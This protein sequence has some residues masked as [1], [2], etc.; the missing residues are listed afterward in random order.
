L[1]TTAVES[2]VQR[3]RAHHEQSERIQQRTGWSPGPAGRYVADMFVAD[4]HR[5]DDPIVTRLR[6]AVTPATTVLDVGGG[7]G[8]YALPLALVCK[9]VTVVEPDPGMVGALRDQMEKHAIS[10][11][12]VVE[13]KWQ[14][15]AAGAADVVLCAHMIYDVVDIQGFVQ[16]L[17]GHARERIM[18]LALLAWPIGS[19]SPIWP[20]V[21]N[22]QRVSLPSVPKLL[23]VLWELGIYPDLEMLALQW[24]AY[25]KDRDAVLARLRRMIYVQPDSEPDARLRAALDELTVETPQGVTLR[26]ARPNR[27]CLVT[28]PANG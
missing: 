15:T 7:A 23:P 8:R 10:N 20:R 3:V 5:E 18:L 27:E 11:I 25:A 26:D 13:E 12:T 17:T 1:A 2:W 22:E 4:P 21:H 6:R 19:F 24:P 14:D 9:H 16:W 28:W